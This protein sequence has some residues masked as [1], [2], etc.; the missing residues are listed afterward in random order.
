[1]A[2]ALLMPQTGHFHKTADKSAPKIRLGQASKL[3]TLLSVWLN[4]RRVLTFMFPWSYVRNDSRPLKLITQHAESVTNTGDTGNQFA[5]V[6]VARL[7]Q[8]HTYALTAY[9]WSSDSGCFARFI[10]FPFFK[11]SISQK[12]EMS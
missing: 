9:S 4:G 2:I 11:V 8:N 3:K 1:M 7:V 5:K 10:I 12:N 6:N